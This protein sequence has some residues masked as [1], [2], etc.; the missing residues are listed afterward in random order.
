MA[1]IW[2]SII[3]ALGVIGVVLGFLS[4]IW[5]LADPRNGL[6]AYISKLR[7]G[8]QKSSVDK[9][10]SYPPAEAREHREI[11]LA[12]PS[13]LRQLLLAAIAYSFMVVAFYG[14]SKYEASQPARISFFP[15][16]LF[17]FK[18]PGNYY[19]ASLTNLRLT[20]AGSVWNWVKTMMNSDKPDESVKGVIP[21]AKTRNALHMCYMIF[22]YLM[23]FYFGSSHGFTLMGLGSRVLK[24]I[25]VIMLTYFIVWLVAVIVY[26]ANFLTNSMGYLPRLASYNMTLLYGPFYLL[27]IVLYGVKFLRK[28]FE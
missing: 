20:S 12:L 8:T 9:K 26:L 10:T 14:T 16:S 6:I 2:H 21:T 25:L 23:I 28:Q 4:S 11:N 22:F 17:D 3:T 5:T 13:F 24:A 27:P 15:N 1:H 7:F 18:A 19:E